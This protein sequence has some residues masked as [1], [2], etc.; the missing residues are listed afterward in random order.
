MRNP[1]T[2]TISFRDRPFFQIGSP[3]PGPLFSENI[4]KDSRPE[5]ITYGSSIVRIVHVEP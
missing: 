1:K 2:S 3:F 5:I 4:D